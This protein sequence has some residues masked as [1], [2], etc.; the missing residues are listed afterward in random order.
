MLLIEEEI[1][2]TKLC[3]EGEEPIVLSSR[4]LIAFV[5][6]LSVA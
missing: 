2:K 5:Y 1:M 4:C 3:G 6:L